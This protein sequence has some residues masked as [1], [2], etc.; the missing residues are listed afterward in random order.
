[1]E[2]SLREYHSRV[3][4]DDTETCG[5]QRLITVWRADAVIFVAAI[6]QLFKPDAAVL[7][8][9]ACCIMQNPRD[10]SE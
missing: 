9:L 4:T 1:M 3:D 7:C 6:M 5:G 2:P 10:G 8:F